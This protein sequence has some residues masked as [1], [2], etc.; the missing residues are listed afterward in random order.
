M[1]LLVGT[2]GLNVFFWGGEMKSWRGD[3][4]VLRDV[5]LGIGNSM[6]FNGER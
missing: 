4:T 6:Q 1:Q 5:I 2:V 3:S